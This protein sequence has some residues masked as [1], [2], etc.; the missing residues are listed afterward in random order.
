MRGRMYRY[1]C[2]RGFRLFGPKTVHCSKT[3]WSLDNDPFCVFTSKG[4]CDRFELLGEGMKHGTFKA[5]PKYKGGF[6]RFECEPGYIMSGNRTVYCDG[7]QWNG[8]KPDC[9][10]PDQPPAQPL[11]T[12]ENPDGET[13]P[14]A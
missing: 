11:L 4:V 6:Y 10:A 2:N 12:M 3:G 13:L 5:L 9:V 7:K 8:T 14:A 1:T